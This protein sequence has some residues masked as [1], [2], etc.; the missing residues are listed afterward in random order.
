MK[1]VSNEY[2]NCTYCVDIPKLP[3]VQTDA[4]HTVYLLSFG[5]E[6]SCIVDKGELIAGKIRFTHIGNR[7]TYLPVSFSDGHYTAI[8]YPFRIDESGILHIFSTDPTNREIAIVTDIG[9]DQSMLYRMQ[10]G[11]FEGANQADFTD[12]KTLYTIKDMP[13]ADYQT[14]RVPDMTAYRLLGLFHWDFCYT[15]SRNLIK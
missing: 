6:A 9:L 8:G 7:V 13:K 4:A 2:A 3:A 12:K 15:Q 1:D 5:K 11:V 14:I 10:E